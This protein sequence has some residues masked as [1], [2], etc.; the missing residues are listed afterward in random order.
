[1][2]AWLHQSDIRLAAQCGKA[3]ICRHVLSCPPAGLC[4]QHPLQALLELRVMYCVEDACCWIR[5][6][7]IRS[8]CYSKVIMLLVRAHFICWCEGRCLRSRIK[9]SAPSF[10]MDKACNLRHPTDP[11]PDHYMIVTYINKVPQVKQARPSALSGRTRRRGRR[12]RAAPPCLPAARSTCRG[13]RS[14]RCRQAGLRWVRAGRA[15]RCLRGS[16]CVCPA[17][18]RLQAA[19]S[20]YS[21]SRW[22]PCNV[23]GPAQ[24]LPT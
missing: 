23:D 24:P 1:V 9:V 2:L 8:I 6:C 18:D 17:V 22:A 13:Q 21:R 4:L 7:W 15:P 10:A 3:S 16:C 20:S 19:V 14:L 11:N 12:C 5:G